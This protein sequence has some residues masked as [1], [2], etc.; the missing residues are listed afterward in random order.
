MLFRQVI[1]PQRKN[2]VMTIASALFLPG[3]GC[4]ETALE[5]FTFAIAMLRLS[6][7]LVKLSVWPAWNGVGVVTEEP[8]AT[9]LRLSLPAIQLRA[10]QAIA[11]AFEPLKPK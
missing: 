5:F 6:P 9:E 10:N 2:S 3:A 4:S 1:K 11:R 7:P 8:I